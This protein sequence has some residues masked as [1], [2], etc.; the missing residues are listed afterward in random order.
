MISPEISHHK[1]TNFT[2]WCTLVSGPITENFPIKLTT[3][4][5]IKI[6][7]LSVLVAGIFSFATSIS[8]AES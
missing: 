3:N 5:P 2:N 4:N 7:L 8:M 6:Y 1:R